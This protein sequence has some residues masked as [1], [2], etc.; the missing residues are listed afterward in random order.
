[1]NIQAIIIII[2]ITGFFLARWMINITEKHEFGSIEHNSWISFILKF[3]L[4]LFSFLTVFV[5]LMFWL[6]NTI[7][8]W[9][10]KKHKIKP[11]RF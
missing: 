11:P 2:Y 4:S 8:E 10:L 7:I 6:I 1:M 3:F 9:D 5:T